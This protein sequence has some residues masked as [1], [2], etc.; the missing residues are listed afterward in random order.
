MTYIVRGY[1]FSIQ[2]L[3]NLQYKRTKLILQCDLNLAYKH[4]IFIVCVGIGTELYLYTIV[5]PLL[6]GGKDSS[7]GQGIWP[8]IHLDITLK[9]PQYR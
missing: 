8:D 4:S 1:K 5:G 3:E 2:I 6:K 7:Y 9:I